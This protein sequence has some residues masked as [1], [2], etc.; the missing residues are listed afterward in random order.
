MSRGSRSEGRSGEDHRHPN[1]PQMIQTIARMVPAPRTYSPAAGA[2]AGSGLGQTFE[3]RWLAGRTLAKV[4][5][6]PERSDGFPPFSDSGEVRFAVGRRAPQLRVRARLD[7][8]S[9]ARP[10]GRLM[11][12]PWPR[13]ARGA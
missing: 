11:P 6:R 10:P 1:K 8:A 7:K 12:A 4:P 9:G 2:L 5:P 3:D 13:T